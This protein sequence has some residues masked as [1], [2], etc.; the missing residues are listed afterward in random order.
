MF[1]VVEVKERE[2]VDGIGVVR[3]RAPESSCPAAWGV[4]ELS[5]AMP[6]ATAPVSWH[7]PA[8][9]HRHCQQRTVAQLPGARLPTQI[10]AMG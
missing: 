8:L 2:S 7:C 10:I 9:H 4:E 3:H 1:V 6:K 5:T